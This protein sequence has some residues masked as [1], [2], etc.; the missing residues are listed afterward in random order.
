[1][2]SL[3]RLM[4]VL[5]QNAHRPVS[6][7]RRAIRTDIEKFAGDSPLFDDYTFIVMKIRGG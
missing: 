4:E 1:M 2:Y 5:R 6:D 7:I 3:E